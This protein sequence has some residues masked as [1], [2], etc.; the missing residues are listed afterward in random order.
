MLSAFNSE[1]S[2]LGAKL[3]NI[4]IHY[5]ICY[6]SNLLDKCNNLI[7]KMERLH[8]RTYNIIMYTHTSRHSDQLKG[9]HNASIFSS[10]HIF[11]LD[12]CMECLFHRNFTHG[13]MQ[14]VVYISIRSVLPQYYTGSETS[15][16]QAS[17]PH[18]H[19]ISIHKGPCNT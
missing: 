18:H 4:M 3:S 13:A 1:M 11:Q 6:F 2:K 15:G 19:C 8:V 17:G 5:A 9:V 7:C 14:F 12:L 10:F 16:T